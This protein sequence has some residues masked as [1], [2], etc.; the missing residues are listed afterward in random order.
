MAFRLAKSNVDKVP[1]LY[2]CLCYSTLL[3]FVAFENL[4]KFCGS[5]KREI[6]M[7]D[8]TTL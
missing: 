7:K 2:V 6:K 4:F 5:V 8:T 1:V 3:I